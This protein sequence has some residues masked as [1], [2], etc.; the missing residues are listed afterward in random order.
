MP[1]DVTF[2]M[3]ETVHRFQSE[4][5]QQPGSCGTQRGQRVD[6][7]AGLVESMGK[8]D[9]G[10]LPPRVC[11]GESLQLRDEGLAA[12]EVEHCSGAQFDGLTVEFCQAGAFWCQPARG[13]EVC[14]R[15]AL[16]PRE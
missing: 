4:L 11:G 13:V 6:L 5:V 15:L 10:M 9:P 14:V 3:V 12:S 8:Q 2:E 1:E 16:P 7:A